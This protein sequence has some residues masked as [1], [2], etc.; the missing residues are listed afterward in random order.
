MSVETLKSKLPAF[1]ADLRTNL[2]NL[3]ADPALT[4]QQRLG[5]LLAS[6]IASRNPAVIEAVEREVAGR[7]SSEAAQAARTAATM[8]SMNNVFY[9]F[10]HLV[11]KPEYGSLPAKLQMNSLGRPGVPGADFAA[12]MLAVSAINGCGMCIQGHEQELRQNGLSAEAVH[13]TVRLAAVVHAIA[14]ALEAGEI[15]Q[16]AKAA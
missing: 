10:I 15:E 9:R 5:A 3:L 8:M 7:L 14:V 13:A 2:T 12:W 1:A 4:E 16:K 6:A 11:S